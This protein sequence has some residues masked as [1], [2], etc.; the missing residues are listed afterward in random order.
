VT[1]ILA[2]GVLD[3]AAAAGLAVPGE[4]SVAGF[5]DIDA[6]AA[7]SPPLTTVAHDLYGRGRVAARLALRLIGGESVRAPRTRA[8]LVV[9]SSTARVRGSTARVRGNTARARSSTARVLRP[10]RR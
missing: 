10:A 4:L 2:L 3:A 8:E 6:A 9:R 1:D 5:D 7:S